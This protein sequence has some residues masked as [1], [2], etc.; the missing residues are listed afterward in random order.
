MSDPVPTCRICGSPQDNHPYRHAFTVTGNLEPVKQ[1]PKGRPGVM[2]DPVGLRL[3]A[4]LHQKGLITE[5]ELSEVV[6]GV[7]ADDAPPKQN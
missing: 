2:I 6:T 7:Q 4:K 5:Q 3:A 1:P